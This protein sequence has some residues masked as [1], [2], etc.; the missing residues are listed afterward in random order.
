MS[1]QSYVLLGHPVRHSAS[2]PMMT[3]AFRTAGLPHTYSPLDVAKP[4]S[5]GRAVQLIR[6]RS[7]DGANVTLPYKRAVLDLVD[8]VDDTAKEAGSANVISIDAKQRLVAHSTDLGAL[9]AEIGAAT[10]QRLRAAIL[11]AGG[12]ATAALAACKRLGF[13]VVGVT[14]RSW[15][16]TASIH[17]SDS[18]QRVR[19]LGGLTAVWPTEPEGGGRSKLSTVMRLQWG[20]L[21]ETAD[22]VIQ[23]TSAGMVGADPGEEIAAVVPFE[24]MKPS[25]VAMDL[26]YRPAMTPFLRVAEQN[27]LRILPGLGMLVRQAE[28]SFKIWTGQD[29]PEGVMRR[30]AEMVVNRGA[31][32]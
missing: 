9:E 26:V 5:L 32:E 20:E 23:A 25:A 6:D 22:I 19:E 7:Y 11:G 15:R 3:A 31:P 30:A 18:A 10:K 16:D 1:L 8:V 24:H 13:A 28:A 17:E 4:E 21:A 29:P 27:G 2:A 14:T 12:A